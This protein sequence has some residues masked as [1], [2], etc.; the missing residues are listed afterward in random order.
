[1]NTLMKRW[2]RWSSALALWAG[3]LLTA[4]A[5]A[6][7]QE[8][9][10]QA[11]VLGTGELR[12]FG[13]RIYSARL[14]SREQPLTENSPFALELTYHRDI[15]RQQLV[16]ASQREIRRLFGTQ[17]SDQQ[18]SAWQVHMQQA[19]VDVAEG[20]RITG[21]FLPGRGARFYAG[22]AFRHGVSD[23]AFARAFFSIWLDAQTRTPELRARLIGAIEP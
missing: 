7:W 4:P 5:Q 11:E 23:Q 15:S 12:L 3:L 18:L 13:F 19:F 17:V 16:E 6:S 10:P 14:W 20:E 2:A 8:S 21:V 9:L 1:M 22:D